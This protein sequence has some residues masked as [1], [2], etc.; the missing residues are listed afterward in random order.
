MLVEASRA[1][2]HN[3]AKVWMAVRKSLGSHLRPFFDMRD[4]TSEKPKLP[5]T[6]VYNNRLARNRSDSGPWRCR[7]SVRIRVHG[8]SEVGCHKG[9][10]RALS[11]SGCM[12]IGGRT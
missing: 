5:A 11:E 9:L 12:S 7:P 2:K 8:Y 3:P 6:E 4:E 10:S 1:G